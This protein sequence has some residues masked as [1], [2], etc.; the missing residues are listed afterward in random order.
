VYIDAQWLGSLGEAGQQAG[1]KK[2]W[3]H[4]VNPPGRF[5]EHSALKGLSAYSMGS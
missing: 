3:A 1:D 4:D 2:Q 5:R